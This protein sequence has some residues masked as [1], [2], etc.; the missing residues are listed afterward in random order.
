MPENA[1]TQHERSALNL[2]SRFRLVFGG[3]VGVALASCTAVSGLLL[4][5]SDGLVLGVSAALAF[6]V[7]SL[8]GALATVRVPQIPEQLGASPA[9]YGLLAPSVVLFVVTVIEWV[10]GAH[11][12]TLLVG[13]YAT[14]LTASVCLVVVMMARTRY[15]VANYPS[16]EAVTVWVASASPA[17]RR[18]RLA[19]C[20]LIFASGGLLLAVSFV[21]ES[22]LQ[23]LSP[24][25]GGFGGSLLG[26]VYRSDRFRVHESGIGITHAA[27]SRFIPWDYFSGYTVSDDELRLVRRLWSDH[28]HDTNSIDDL[29]GV[30]SAIDEHLPCLSDDRTPPE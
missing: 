4:G 13:G 15:V 19:L 25:L 23:F 16:S 10:G 1:S 12:G 7:G 9:R 27:A 28:R 8:F 3:Y 18:Q 5:V 20:V 11:R 21:V 17:A 2:D 26:L 22:G 24:V 6:P 14:L 30:V 29:D